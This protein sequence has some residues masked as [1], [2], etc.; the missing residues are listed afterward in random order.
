MDGLKVYKKL[1]QD[2]N[3]GKDQI[4]QIELSRMIHKRSSSIVKWIFYISIF[5][6][7]ALTLLNVF[8]KTDWQ[9]LKEMGLY[10]F[11]IVVSIISYLIPLIFIY[12]FYRNY[13]RIC[14]TSSTKDLINNILKTRRTVKYY[15]YSMLTIIAF[16]ILYGFDASLRSDEYE[17]VLENL[18]ANGSLIAWIIAIV[19]TVIVLGF[20]FIIYQLLYGILLK[21][22][23]KNYKELIRD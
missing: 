19:F 4:G 12:L 10:S 13:K 23:Q 3:L 8:S 18:G 9:Q 1:W 15:I 7:V 21:R 5:E 20:F 2:Q 11:F 22:L 16:S 14:V 17:L 6:M